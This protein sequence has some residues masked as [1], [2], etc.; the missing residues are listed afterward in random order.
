MYGIQLGCELI[1]LEISELR[2]EGW[3]DWLFGWESIE[4]VVAGTAEG[5]DA[6]RLDVARR[7]AAQA[8]HFIDSAI[9]HLDAA[10]AKERFGASGDWMVQGFEFGKNPA[11]S[12]NEF[13][14][15]FVIDGD[16]YGRWY[17]KFQDHGPPL[18]CTPGAFSR[19]GA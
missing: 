10:I 15:W 7:V 6:L 8:Q 18:G 13:E 5:P 17:V 2:R 9:K 4:F 11:D 12:V 14:V 19:R 16:I 1:P 3:D